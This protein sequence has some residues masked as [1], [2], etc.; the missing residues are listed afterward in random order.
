MYTLQGQWVL[1]QANSFGGNGHIAWRSEFLLTCEPP[2]GALSAPLLGLRQHQMDS[3]G[4]FIM[5]R[6]LSLVDCIVLPPLLRACVLKH[7]R[8][9]EGLKVGLM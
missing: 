5:G 7:W 9:V 6:Q 1:A 2:P 8:W 3:E 4:P